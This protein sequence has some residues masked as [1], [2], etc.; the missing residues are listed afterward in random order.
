MTT[1]IYK[2]T[3]EKRDGIFG[4]YLS[5][6]YLIKNK[7]NPKSI[8][9]YMYNQADIDIFS[10]YT[11]EL[12]ELGVKIEI[13][14][15]KQNT[16]IDFTYIDNN[17]NIYYIDSKARFDI[18][19]QDAYFEL[20]NT[21]DGYDLPSQYTNVYMF[22]LADRSINIVT[23][24]YDILIKIIRNSEYHNPFKNFKYKN[25]KPAFVMSFEELQDKMKL[26]RAQHN[27]KNPHLVM[28]ILRM[29]GKR[30]NLIQ[31]VEKLHKVK[32]IGHDTP[33]RHITRNGFKVSY[34]RKYKPIK[35]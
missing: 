7:K 9:W 22:V 20:K 19:Y 34:R 30:S 29:C 32:V 3:Q 6:K 18:N 15:E 35:C 21:D 17:G 10:E 4:E 16:G 13:S 31:H 1:D 26:A 14:S 8:V 23:V 11:K 25:N 28:D 12:S 5:I 2:G 33:N 24:D 27:L